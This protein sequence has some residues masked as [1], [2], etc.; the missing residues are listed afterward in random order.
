MSSRLAL[1]PPL[2]ASK[3]FSQSFSS[4]RRLRDSSGKSDLGGLL[5]ACT[6][7]FAVRFGSCTGQILKTFFVNWFRSRLKAYK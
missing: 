7:I 2:L 3:A 1:R 5:E 6:G 4:W